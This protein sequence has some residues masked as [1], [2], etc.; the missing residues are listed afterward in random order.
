[1]QQNV[2]IKDHYRL[3][4]PL[5]F[6]NFLICLG[7]PAAGAEAGPAPMVNRD[8]PDDVEGARG[9]G[10]AKGEDGCCA[11]WPK[12]N[13]PEL[14]GWGRVKLVPPAGEVGCEPKPNGAFVEGAGN[15]KAKGEG[16]LKVDGLLGAEPDV[17]CPNGFTFCC[18][19]P[20]ENG[21]EAVAEVGV[22][23]KEK[24]PVVDGLC[25]VSSE[26]FVDWPKENPADVEDT[27]PVFPNV[28]NGLSS[29]GLSLGAKGFDDAEGAALVC[30]N[31]PNALGSSDLSLGA[32]G[33]DGD[34]PPNKNGE[35]VD[36]GEVVFCD[37]PPNNDVPV[38]GEALNENP[39][40]KVR[41]GLLVPLFCCISL[42]GLSSILNSVSGFLG[43]VTGLSVGTTALC[44]PNRNGCLVE[45]SADVLP[46]PLKLKVIG[47]EVAVAAAVLDD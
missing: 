44:W 31:P 10:P 37:P 23:L 19:V 4:T 27:A 35:V 17:A 38:E 30:P 14:A 7:P 3:T 43:G 8:P 16:W 29:S 13:P 36:N 22:V 40:P 6:G 5:R 11:G 20:K 46:P 1:M 24:E 42:V 28:S 2:D 21:E 47:G 32:K 39:L 12:A 18:D 34:E 26:A 25:C 9:I 41:V 45:T 33:F 15:P